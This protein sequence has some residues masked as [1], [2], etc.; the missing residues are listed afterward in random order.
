MSGGTWCLRY[1]FES[2]RVCKA[3]LLLGCEGVL[4]SGFAQQVVHFSCALVLQRLVPRPLNSWEAEQGLCR[5]GVREVPAQW[6]R[7]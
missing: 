3:A 4:D 2:C 7:R 5:D 6:L 1:R